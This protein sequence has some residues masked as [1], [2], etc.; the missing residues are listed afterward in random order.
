[1]LATSVLLL[2]SIRFGLTFEQFGGRIYLASSPERGGSRSSLTGASGQLHQPFPFAEQTQTDAMS[3]VGILLVSANDCLDRVA[4]RVR[5]VQVNVVSSA[6]H[7]NDLRAWAGVAHLFDVVGA[8]ERVVLGAQHD[9]G[10]G[11]R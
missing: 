10:A 8:D 7:G 9:G 2:C 4:D 6:W 5:A 3:G 1:M 11:D